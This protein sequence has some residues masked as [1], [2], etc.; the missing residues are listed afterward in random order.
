MTDANRDP[1]LRRAIDELQRLPETDPAAIRNVVMAA[2]AARVAPSDEDTRIVIPQRA[3]RRWTIGAL[4]AAAA[5]V[6]FVARGVWTPR[7]A[8]VQQ[9][10]DRATT[11]QTRPTL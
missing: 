9:S 7:S 5:I 2:A 10:I 4:V 11:T 6:G 3:G 1:V 8:A